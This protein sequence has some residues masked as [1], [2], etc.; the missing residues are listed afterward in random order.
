[1]FTE[2]RKDPGIPNSL[3]FKESV[4]REAE[5][6]KRKV[7]ITRVSKQYSIRTEKMSTYYTVLKYKLILILYIFFQNQCNFIYFAQIEEER[8]KLKERRK[9]EREKL[10]NKKRN[11]VSLVKDAEKKTQ[12]F[13]RKVH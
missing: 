8:E 13:E 6:R 12:A 5:E 2:K 1:M 9:K 3:P 10:Q 7:F 11:L 4:L